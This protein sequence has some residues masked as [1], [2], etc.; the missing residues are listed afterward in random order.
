MLMNYKGRPPFRA[1]VCLQGQFLWIQRMYLTCL[2]DSSTY[3]PPKGGPH[4]EFINRRRS[5]SRFHQLKGGPPL[6]FINKK[7]IPSTKKGVRLYGQF[8]W[9]QRYIVLKSRFTVW[10][11]LATLYHAK[12][13]LVCVDWCDDSRINLGKTWAVKEEPWNK[14]SS[15]AKFPSF[16]DTLCAEN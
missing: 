16:F 13:L 15:L 1:G 11:F 8:L 5:T 7:G 12:T 3:S 4:L 14:L 6:D 9:I 2:Q 10:D